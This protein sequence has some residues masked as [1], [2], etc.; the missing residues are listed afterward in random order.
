MAPRRAV[1]LLLLAV[2]LVAGAYLVWLLLHAVRRAGAQS[3]ASWLLA[4]MAAVILLRL[5]S[6][7]RRR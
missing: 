5:T 6:G 4:G 3:G 1:R 7:G 2:A